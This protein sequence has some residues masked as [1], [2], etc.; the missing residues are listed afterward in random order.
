MLPC[1]LR[2]LPEMVQDKYIEFMILASTHSSFLISYDSWVSWISSTYCCV[3]V[4]SV[5]N[6]FLRPV[7]M[8]FWVSHCPKCCLAVCK[9][10]I[11]SFCWGLKLILIRY[12]FK[13]SDFHTHKHAFFSVVPS[14]LTMASYL[15]QWCRDPNM[16]RATNA[17]LKIEIDVSV[18]LMTIRSFYPIYF[19]FYM[20][21]RYQKAWR[22]AN[23]GKN[24]LTLSY[25]LCNIIWFSVYY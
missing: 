25:I 9:I 2:P 17:Q 10:L 19:N 23:Y 20:L 4:L 7:S 1:T 11:R 22:I 18:L 5:P 16:S 6:G 21:T 12:R 3:P 8:S 24:V 15:E 13:K 14:K